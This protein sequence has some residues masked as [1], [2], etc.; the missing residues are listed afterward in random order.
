MSQQINLL[1]KPEKKP[2][3]SAITAMLILLL[4]CIA[5]GSFVWSGSRDLDT[6]Q[7][8]AERSS[9]TLASQRQLVQ[10]LQKKLND[11]D[12]QHS[13]SAQIAALELQTLVSRDLLD[14][15]RA[16][17]FGSL[18]GYGDQLTEFARVPQK[19]VWVTRVTV[20]DAGRSLRVEGR[21]LKKEQILPYAAGLNSV[22]KKYGIALTGVEVIPAL[23]TSDSPTSM[24]SIWN[25]KLY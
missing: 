10:A 14:R 6:A 17:E 23:P 21:A 20:S 22:L 12:T 7:A 11:H 1:R 4:W 18:N 3:L 2:L 25:F 9:Q 19:G 5:L 13:I 24:A 15:L 8:A 16:G